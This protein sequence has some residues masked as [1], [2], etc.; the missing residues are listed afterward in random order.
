MKQKILV[1]DDDFAVRTSLELLFENHDFAVKT[2]GNPA[3]ALALLDAESFNLAVIDMNFSRETSGR[4]GLE[5]LSRM[6]AAAAGMPV[7]LLTAWGS[8][9]LAVEGMRSGAANFVTKPWD[10]ERLLQDVQ[11]AL[12]LCA[13]PQQQ[14]NRT[15]L[16]SL[17]RFGGIYGSDPRFVEVLETVGR[18]ARTDA[19]IL[20]LGE[21]GTGKERIAEAIH[22]NSSRRDKP[23]VK[24]NLGGI[25]STLFESEMFG[26][27]R[28]SFTDAKHD[29]VG[30]FELADGGTIFL[31]EI[32]ELD[33]SSQ[34]KL[35]RVLQDRT[36]EVLGSSITRQLNIRVIAATNRPLAHMVS[37]GSFREDLFYRINLITVQIPPLRERRG[38]I[39]TLIAAFLDDFRQQY[40]RDGISISPAA[41]HWL[42]ELP[43]P[44]NVRELKNLLE[45]VVLI[46]PHDRLER[47]DFLTQHQPHQR[48]TPQA[49]LPPV[50]SMTVEEMECSMITQALKHHKNNISKVARSLGLSRAALYRRM[51]KYGISNED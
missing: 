2:A 35:L 16:D 10:N 31:D 6:Q 38:D 26:H 33:L 18:V 27:R 32:G 23:F 46:T 3:E 5:L 1:V 42:Q 28:G 41:V 45:R 20:I 24:V 49:S 11:T 51:Q 9:D 43:Y 13:A 48:P 17:Y 21:S 15:Q 40:Q 30:R 8:I 14:V 19:S 29:R 4:E 22:Q 47:D 37:Q 36:Y 7:I 34:V 39:P 12:D 44:G 25:S 50:G